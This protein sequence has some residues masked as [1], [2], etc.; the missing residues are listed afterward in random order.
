M[1]RRIP[2]GG[3]GKII[4]EQ[5][6]DPTPADT[7][8]TPW[9]II[10]DAGALARLAEAAA[11]ETVVAVD[12]EADSM[13]HFREKVC[14]VQM[15]AGLESVV[16][17][18]LAVPDLAPLAPL[19]ARDDVCKVFHG[20]DYDVR[21]LYRDFGIVI[22]NL[23]DTQIAATFLGF[24]ETGLES[25]LRHSFDV[26]LDKKFQKKD[27]SRR[28]LPAEMV[29]YAARDVIHLRPLADLLRRELE[30]RGRLAWVEEECDLLRRVRP[31]AVDDGPHFL[32]FKG[33]GRL[34]RRSLAVLEALLEW[35]HRMAAKKD[36]PLFKI[37]GSRPL[38]Q[39]AQKKP[40][41]VEAL[42][43]SGALSAKQIKIHG[44]ELVTAIDGAMSLPEG[45][46]PRY[47]R[48]ARLSLPPQVPARMRALRAWRDPE[49]ERLEL[50]QSVLFSK[51]QLATIAHARPRRIEDFEGLADIR[52]W[53]IEGF[54]R[55]ILEVLDT[56]P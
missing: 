30:A 11:A 24:R 41:S 39:L 27:W 42:A 3:Q 19:F 5:A 56:C 23:F 8:S 16:I 49:A 33:A 17:D 40:T 50:D 6:R 31:A 20:A 25:V 46:L 18:P 29:A 38:L 53:Q 21:S 15:A 12:L 2:T 34:D 55:R 13:Y 7:T 22:N 48:R 1:L 45:R 32:R 54:G 44:S 51:A 26:H 10:E 35:R 36:R 9:R 28:P 52:R 14:L 37:L 47:P 4:R 43:A